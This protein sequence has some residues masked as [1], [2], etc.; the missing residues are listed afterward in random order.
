MDLGSDLPGSSTGAYRHGPGP[1][2]ARQFNRSTGM[3]L[4]R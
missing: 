4:G 1:L 3:D 2:F